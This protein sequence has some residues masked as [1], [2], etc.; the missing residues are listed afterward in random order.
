MP[1]FIAVDGESFTVNG[2]HTYTLLA[3]S[4][5]DYVYSP[6]GLS[7]ST[8]FE[9]LLDSRQAKGQQLV[10]FAFNYDVNMILR[11][12]DTANV[13]QLYKNGVTWW[14]GYRVEWIPGKMFQLSTN[15]RS[16]QVH[17]TFG[18]FQ[19]SFIKALQQWHIDVPDHIVSGKKS[20]ST[21]DE[22]S[23]DD[24]IDYCIAECDLL[25]TMM[26]K[27]SEACNAVGYNPWSWMGAGSIANAALRKHSIR[28]FLP[29]TDIW[30]DPVMQSIIKRSYFGGRTELFS[31]GRFPELYNYD[32]NSAY[33]FAAIELP[34]LRGANVRTTNVYEPDAPFALW[35]VSWSNA[36]RMSP[37]PY[38]TDNRSIL[39]PVNG[40]GWYHAIEV[41]E[42]IAAGVADITIE[43]GVVI[44]PINVLRPFAWI[45]DTYAERQK[46]KQAGNLGE[47][48]VL[49]LALNSIY[50]KLAQGEGYKGRIP[51]YQCY[52]WAGYITAHCRAGMMKL[53]AM[54]PNDLVM[55]ATDGIFL[56]RPLDV[57]ETPGLGGL[58]KGTL[59]DAFIAQPGLYCGTNQ[60][61]KF[62]IRTRGFFPREIDFD[63]VTSAWDDVREH[64]K[65]RVNAR[66]FIGIGT[67]LVR[68]SIE[69]WRTWSDYEKVISLY[70]SRKFVT[71]TDNNG[72]SIELKA[73]IFSGDIA[74]S[75]EYVP[76]GRG[77]K[78]S[79][80]ELLML[81]EQIMSFEQPEVI[82]ND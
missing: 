62:Y 78:M 24:I 41:A 6:T 54:A 17:D 35:K 76:K 7:T 42:A 74:L 32:I 29:N 9:F 71:G 52:Y 46:H 66:R 8:C 1:D 37:F 20:R 47:Q 55:I 34:D 39:Y 31:M 25:T 72:D 28:D 14:Y 70:P 40:R 18:Y 61:D 49:K 59:S 65:V 38:R 48:Q 68:R 58:E 5:G 16:V 21:F 22:S 77:S 13:I 36:E 2:K 3:N 33:P 44:E 10:A 27:V 12:M 69:G 19:C 11:D 56:T 67:C 73:P 43:K 26:D 53:A 75:R 64:A 23:V 63:E 79:D 15:Q 81:A 45:P 51:P 57:P 4:N 50:G 82:T 60:H 80:E 30:N